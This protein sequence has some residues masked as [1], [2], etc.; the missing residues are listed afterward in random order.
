MSTVTVTD[1]VQGVDA[2]LT[3]SKTANSTTTGDTYTYPITQNYIKLTNGGAYDLL[4]SVGKHTHTLIHPGDTFEAF[5]DFDSFTIKSFGGV[6]AFT[7]VSKE[8]GTTPVDNI[9]TLWKYLAERD[10]AAGGDMALTA[11]NKTSS[12]A[13]INDAITGTAK[14]HEVEYTVT[15]KNAKGDKTHDWFNGNM[16]V[17]VAKTSNAGVVAIKDGLEYITFKDGIGKIKVVMTGT[18]VQNDVVTLTV[19]ANKVMGY[20]VAAKDITDTLGA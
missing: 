17:S 7:V 11:T 5:V 10:N 6:S 16:P 15:L 3:R 9:T 8:L 13:T 1:V 20:A 14:K 12:T 2:Y 18:W 4:I 19:A